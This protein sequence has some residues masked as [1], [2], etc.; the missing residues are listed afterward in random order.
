M[1]T[2]FLALQVRQHRNQYPGHLMDLLECGV[3]KK[4]FVSI[5]MEYVLCVTSSQF[6]CMRMDRERDTGDVQSIMSFLVSLTESSPGFRMTWMLYF[7]SRLDSS[8]RGILIN[9]FFL[10]WY[11]YGRRDEGTSYISFMQTPLFH[12]CLLSYTS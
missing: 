11:F 10:S 3:H 4:S 5:I 6:H 2:I 12:Y 9:I 1:L 8:Y 7:Y